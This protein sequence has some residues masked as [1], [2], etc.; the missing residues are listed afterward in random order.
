MVLRNKFRFYLQR[1]WWHSSV[2]LGSTVQGTQVTTRDHHITIPHRVRI[3]LDTWF[4]RSAASTWCYHFRSALTAEFQGQIEI[5]PSKVSLIGP[6]DPSN[7]A[8]I[9]TQTT[10][11]T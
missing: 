2:V 1:C 3:L 5:E 8:L 11:I 7:D 10:K 9:S 6:S 4:L